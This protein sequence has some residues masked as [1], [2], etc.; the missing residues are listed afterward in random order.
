VSWN[1]WVMWC[2]GS[3]SGAHDSKSNIQVGEKKWCMMK[4]IDSQ[5]PNARHNDDQNL[6][7]IGSRWIKLM[8]SHSLAFQ[9]W[10]RQVNKLGFP[11]QKLQV[12]IVCKKLRFLSHVFFLLFH[13]ILSIPWS[14]RNY[15][16]T[17]KPNISINPR[18]SK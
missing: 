8:V 14:W 15:T 1:E 5:I 11:K 6:D 17:I 10:S 9:S 16:K 4:I 13:L 12:S 3:I 7:D 2:Q 18:Y